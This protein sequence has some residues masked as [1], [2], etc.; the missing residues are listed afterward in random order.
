[1]SEDSLQ[2]LARRL[3]AFAAERDWGRFHAPKNLASALIVEAAELL[4]HFQWMG[5]AES[6]ELAP[7]Q[8][9]EVAMEMAD[10]LLYLVQLSNELGI[11]LVKAAQT[12]L[13]RNEVRFAVADDGPA[14]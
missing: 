3:Q 4:E 5:E 10:V 6:R 12:K 7:A 14:A 8:R 1:M 13:A 2:D 11:D 9:E